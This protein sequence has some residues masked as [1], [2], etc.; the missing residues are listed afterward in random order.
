MAKRLPAMPVTTRVIY[1]PDPAPYRGELLHGTEAQLA[2]WRQEQHLLYVR[3]K[4][5][6]AAIAEHDRRVR[7]FM[8]GLGATVGVGVVGGLVVAGWLL[9]GLLGGLGLLAIPFVVAGLA[10][11]GHRCVTV[12]QHWH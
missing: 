12:V 2:A 5:R 4:A 6:Q 10:V 8:L 3:W 9:A 11:G 1:Y 7:R